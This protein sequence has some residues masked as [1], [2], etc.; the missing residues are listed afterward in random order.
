MKIYRTFFLVLSALFF[1]A[2]QSDQESPLVNI[3]EF[4]S[5]FSYDVRYATDDNFLEQIDDCA[6]PEFSV[7][8]H[9]HIANE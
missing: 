6:H 1:L 3:A 9:R 2:M 8:R 7:A 4:D 5:K